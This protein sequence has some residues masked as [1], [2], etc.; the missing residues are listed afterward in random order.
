MRFWCTHSHIQFTGF[1][2][3]G[4]WKQYALIYQEKECRNCD[5]RKVK[6]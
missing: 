1:H 5:A 2:R 6:Y 3:W 4:A